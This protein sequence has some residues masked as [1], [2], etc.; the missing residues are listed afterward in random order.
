[1]GVAFRAIH[2]TATMNRKP[3]S[4]PTTG[5]STMKITIFWIPDHTSTRAP[6]AASAA[7]TSPPIRAWD[8]DTGS[9]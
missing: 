9:P 6:A 1:M 5:E 3:K 2:I 7:P 4:I 8:D